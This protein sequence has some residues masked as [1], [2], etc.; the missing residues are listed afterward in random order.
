MPEVAL[1]RVQL[2]VSGASNVASTPS[3][4]LI[5]N[6]AAAADVHVSWTLM[7]PPT[8]HST[9]QPGFPPVPER[10]MCVFDPT[11]VKPVNQG[12]FTATAVTLSPAVQEPFLPDWNEQLVAV[13]EL[14]APIAPGPTVP[15]SVPVHS[16]ATAPPVADKSASKSL[17]TDVELMLI[18]LVIGFPFDN[19]CKADADADATA[20]IANTATS[21]RPMIFIRVIMCSFS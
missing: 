14:T 21:A 19:H 7:I 3:D 4:T 5:A 2:A 13:I 20:E 16:M 9:L 6:G 10:G 8:V 11:V 18:G 15:L 12:R 1:P 17:P